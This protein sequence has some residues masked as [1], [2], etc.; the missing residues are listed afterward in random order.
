MAEHD[1]WDDLNGDKEVVVIPMTE[2]L[3]DAAIRRI[4]EEYAPYF[5]KGGPLN[6]DGLEFPADQQRPRVAPFDAG[7]GAR[8]K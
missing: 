5:R 2:E 6:P 7:S 1:T 3:V 8:T 4:H